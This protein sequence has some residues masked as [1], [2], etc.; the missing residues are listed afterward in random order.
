[1]GVQARFE[2]QQIV[3]RS[4]FD[5]LDSEKTARGFS[6]R[7]FSS[8]LFYFGDGS[9]GRGTRGSGL[10]MLTLHGWSFSV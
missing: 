9:L 7:S 10:G 4:L 3:D 5:G 1:M 6:L 2:A 8:S